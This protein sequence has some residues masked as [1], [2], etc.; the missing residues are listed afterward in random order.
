MW[1]IGVRRN[2]T[3]ASCIATTKCNKK[4]PISASH[5]FSYTLYIFPWSTISICIQIK[6]SAISTWKIYSHFFCNT[7]IFPI[8]LLY[9]PYWF[10]H[11]ESFRFLG[12]INDDVE[13]GKWWRL[14]K[15][16]RIELFNREKQIFNKFELYF[17]E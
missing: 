3:S 8:I 6:S 15:Q 7:Y 14:N 2:L 12:T 13:L 1:K 5:R 11:F 16:T 4:E 9:I 10:S 17:R